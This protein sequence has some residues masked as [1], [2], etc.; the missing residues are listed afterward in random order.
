MPYE[1]EYFDE[2]ENDVREAKSWYKEQK[3]GLEIRF[4]KA[5]ETTIH[6]ILQ[7]PFSY[8]LRYKKIRIAHPKIFPYNIHF[9]VDESLQKVTITAIVHGKRNQKTAKNRI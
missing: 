4:T 7:N 1:L 8:A 9:Y 5:I 6:H 3:V 2:V